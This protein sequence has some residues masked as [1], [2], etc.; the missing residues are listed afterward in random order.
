MFN[1][2]KS[3]CPHFLLAFALLGVL[4]IR[5]ANADPMRVSEED[6][7]KAAVTKVAPTLP[8]LA[9]QAHITGKVVV[10]MTVTEDGSVEKVDIVSGNPILGSA[11]VNA[12]KRWT[13]QP[14]K[15]NGQP[16]K[17]LVRAAFEFGS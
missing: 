3:I 6:G 16:S 14:F 7:R 11:V 2:T 17:A 15:S 13:F 8:P 12:T 9:R 5:S 4:S 10:E 1:R